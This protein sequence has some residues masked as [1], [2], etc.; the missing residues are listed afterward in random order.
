M[1]TSYGNRTSPVLRGAWVLDNIYGTPPEAP[2]PGV[3]AFKE[4]EVGQ[5]A[6][7][8]RERLERHRTN[9]SCNGCHGVMDPLG[10]ALENF[11]VVGAWRERDRDADSAIDANGKLSNGV[12][13]GSPAELNR[14][15][16]AR[17]D[18]FVQALT[19]KVM[20]FALGRGLRYQDMPAVRAIVRQAATDDYR[21]EAIL[22]G[23]VLSDAFQKR[24]MPPPPDTRQAAVRK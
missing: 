4:T 18:Q 14:A 6:L 8:V 15:L 17:P 16:L 1:G 20:V 13:V 22:R 2:P 12:H 5:K 3:E 24:L 23:I 9:P 7:T 21:F 11:D 19:E 10:F